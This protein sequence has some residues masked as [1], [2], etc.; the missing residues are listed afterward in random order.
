MAWH[1]FFSFFLIFQ[2]G[3]SVGNIKLAQATN[4]DK[5]E[6]ASTAGDMKLL[7]LYQEHLGIAETDYACITRMPRWEFQRIVRDLSQF[8]E[9]M[10]MNIKV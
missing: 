2:E 9:N 1:S 8:G 4:M 5:E 3:I 10:V 6:E 7:N